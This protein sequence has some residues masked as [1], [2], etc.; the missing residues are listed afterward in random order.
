MGL[1][2]SVEVDI[3][4]NALRGQNINVLKKDLSGVAQI[5]QF[6]QDFVAGHVEIAREVLREEQKRGFPTKPLT[7]V[8]KVANKEEILVKPFGEIAYF[9]RLTPTEALLGIYENILKR[10][11]IDTGYYK[12][13]NVVI[14]DGKVVATSRSMLLTWLKSS[15]SN[16]GAGSQVIFV[17]TA[18]YARKLERRGA[19]R[20]AGG[21]KTRRSRKQK[22]RFTGKL[23]T[24][25]NGAYFL[26]YR[27][28][29]R[30]LPPPLRAFSA[31][32]FIPGNLL[33]DAIPPSTFRRVFAETRRNGGGAGR[34]YLYPAIVIRL[35]AAG[36]TQGASQGPGLL[37]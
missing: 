24:A 3:K 1:R 36:I 8:D 27:A 30:L 15:D 13:Q 26:A 6:N 20:G 2:V 37:Q 32:R 31:F 4:D 14:V 5:R 21:Q 19:R 29:K 10:S 18:P 28:S 17:N 22:S 25:P 11:I 12:S 16:I 33:G 9:A 23:V 7:V 34:P 35:D